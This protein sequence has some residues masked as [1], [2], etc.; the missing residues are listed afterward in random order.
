[1]SGNDA[2]QKLSIRVYKKKKFLAGG[3]G[4][5]GIACGCVLVFSLLKGNAVVYQEQ[6]CKLPEIGIVLNFMVG[7][8]NFLLVF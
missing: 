3:H 6:F 7:S 8:G 5:G 4:V 2:A 1:M